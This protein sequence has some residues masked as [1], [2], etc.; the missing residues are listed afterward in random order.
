MHQPFR[1]IHA[2]DFHLDRPLRG[3]AEVPDHLRGA[4]IDV[5]YRAAERVFDA[6]I[7]ERVDFVVLAGDIVDPLLSGPRGLVFLGKQFERL[8]T[9]GIKIYWATGRSDHFER[10]PQTAWPDH[11]VLFPPG[12]PLRVVHQRNGEPLA[13]ILGTSCEQRKKIRTAD[14]Q[15][16]AG[17]LFAVAVAYGSTEA[18]VV[19]RQMA[20]YWALGGEHARRSLLSGPITAH[21][22]GT[23]QG[24]RPQESGAHGCTLVHV[25]ETQRVRTSFITTDAVRYQVERV[26]VNEPTTREQLQ[27]ILDERVREL[28]GDPFGPDLLV[29]WTVLGSKRLSAELT[30]GTLAGDLTAELRAA[31]GQ[32]RPAAWTVSI[33][34]ESAGAIPVERYEEDTLLGEFLRTLRHYVDHPEEPLDLGAYLNERHAAGH[35]GAA[36]ALDDTALRRRVLA[37]VAR[38]G[39][40]LLGPEEPLP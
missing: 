22:C 33:D 1:F 18:D 26:A 14:F 31:H 28:V 39:V 35:V 27:Q 13:Q 37:D 40:E 10:W 15:V 25:D 32:R 34:A 9:A 7:R 6:A 38:L 3:L 21:Y 29:Q 30:R 5:P 17:G 4:L 20:N 23:P 36:V 16:D 24:R 12:R 8:G 11:V 2:S 19:S